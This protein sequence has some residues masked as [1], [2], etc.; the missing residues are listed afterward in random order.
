MKSKAALSVLI[1]LLIF[2][3]SDAAT[4]DKWVLLASKTVNFQAERDQVVVTQ[5]LG[6][7]K[8]I[9]LAVKETGVHFLDVTVVFANGRT[10]DLPV[11]NFIAPGGRTKEFD[12]PG[13]ARIIQK[14]LL[15]YKTVPVGD[16]GKGLVEVWGLRN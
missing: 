5:K 1:C 16:P 10:V 7:F 9:Q 4:K 14:I 2:S 11:Q 12:L 8:R 6:E 3:A 13:K 15:A